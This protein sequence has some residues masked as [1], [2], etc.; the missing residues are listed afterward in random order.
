MFPA[1]LRTSSRLT[2]FAATFDAPAQIFL[3]QLSP[4][5]VAG[6]LA[7]QAIW[8]G[9]MLVA[10]ARVMDRGTRKLVTQGG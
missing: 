1:G 9:V 5:G 2:P 8:V 4:T 6:T 7:V 3:E 10:A